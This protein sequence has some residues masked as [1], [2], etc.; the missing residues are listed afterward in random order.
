MLI[1]TIRNNMN[2]GTGDDELKHHFLMALGDK[3]LIAIDGNK[4]RHL[5]PLDF[6]SGERYTKMQEHLSQLFDMRMP[7]PYV[8]YEWE[9]GFDVHMGVLYFFGKTSEFE[10]SL[11]NFYPIKDTNDFEKSFY[12]LVGFPAYALKNGNE[13][14]V[15]ST[16]IFTPLDA[17]GSVVK[18]INDEYSYTIRSKPDEKLTRGNWGAMALGSIMIGMRILSL[19]NVK[20][21]EMRRI[22]PK[23]LTKKQTRRGDLPRITFRV[24]DVKLPKKIIR[25]EDYESSENGTE[26]GFH[27][28]IGHTADYRTNPLFGKLYGVF[29]VPTHFRGSR[30]V[31]QV[32]KR[33]R[34]MEEAS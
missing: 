20:N 5:V 30:D 33:Y 11:V 7:A 10:R 34:L 23:P 8:W 12:Y 26:K 2:L 6:K 13:W 31:G 28:V 14:R 16:S 21:I 32:K 18:D 9:T 17:E 4:C 29:Y 22:P 19:L 3:R 25:Y 1:D 27:Q 24:L 15:D